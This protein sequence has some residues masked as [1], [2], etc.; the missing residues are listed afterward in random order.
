MDIQKYSRNTW[1]S[2]ELHPKNQNRD[3]L[4]WIFLVDTLNFSFWTNACGYSVEYKGV[5]YTG[6][7]SLCAVVNRALDEGIPILSPVY[8]KQL[9]MNMIEHLFRGNGKCP[10][11]RERLHVLNDVAEVLIKVPLNVAI[12]DSI[13]L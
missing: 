1:S 12:A 5:N 11:L 4:A 10:M 9:T 3:T 2:H 13:G 8:W 7:W 6:Y